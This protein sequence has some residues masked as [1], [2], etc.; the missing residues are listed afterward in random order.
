MPW[1][2]PNYLHCSQGEHYGWTQTQCDYAFKRDMY[3][4][5]ENSLER[6]RFFFSSVEN[7]L[8]K[9]ADKV[10]RCKSFGADLY[11]ICSYGWQILL[12]EKSSNLVQPPLRQATW[13][14]YKVAERLA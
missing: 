10:K 11:Y 2:I 8:K 6:K 5:C 1:I 4:L 13:R 7:L 14:P 9:L 12:G 3:K